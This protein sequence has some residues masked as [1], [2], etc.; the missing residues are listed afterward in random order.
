MYN[1]KRL[2]KL[3]KKERETLGYRKGEVARKMGFP[4]Y[5]TLSSI[6]SGE[7]EI[8]AWELFKLAEIY[9][10]KVD[11][12]IPGTEKPLEPRI[13]WRNP[14][15]ISA[16][17]KAE[18]KFVEFC[19][20]Y[21]KLLELTE[22]SSIPIPICRLSNP[23]KAT[24][25][26]KGYG[27]VTELAKEYGRLLNFG[28]RP[29]YCLSD[30][31]EQTM[32]ILVLYMDLGPGGSGA[33]TSSGSGDAILVNSSDA[34]WRRNYD[35]AHE[36][37]HILT[38]NTFTDD[39]IYSTKKGS[40]SEIEQWADFFASEIL[41]PEDEVR[42]EFFKRVS[43]NK[44]S[45][46]DLVQIA[47]DFRVSIEALLWRLVNLKFV[48]RATVSK[49]L[50]EDKAKEIDRLLRADDREGEKPYLST[51]YIA[52]AIKAFEIGRISKLK[53]AEYVGIPFSRVSSFLAKYGYDENEDYSLD[54]ATA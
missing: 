53:F 20:N 44:I 15:R 1:I 8:K 35:L 48:T 16:T 38:W 27:Y 23:D 28:S 12:F 54:F 11:Y 19:G 43:E 6:E 4:N 14:A 34:P 17:L 40:K 25:R 52:L 50:E 37:F 3:L 10:R 30:V 46:I 32:G 45:H 39:E 51:R 7:R 42:K 26:R 22:D 49:C 31:L 24:F 36:F 13:L 2:G 29:A 5:Q 9:G 47:R 21:K 18:R 41:L 33:S